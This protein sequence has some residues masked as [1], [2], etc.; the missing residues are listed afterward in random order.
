MMDAGSF[1]AISK[2]DPPVAARALH[3]ALGPDPFLEPFVGGRAFRLRPEPSGGQPLAEALDDMAGKH[4]RFAHIRVAS[5][6][7][8]AA[9]ALAAAGFSRIETLVTYSLALNQASITAA[10][11]Q[12]AQ[13]RQAH[14]GDLSCCRRI[15]EEAFIWNRFSRDPQMSTA[16]AR[17][18]KGE[19]MA[20]N[21]SGRAEMILVAETQ[22]EVGGFVA[23][24]RQG[25][26]AV[27]D[28]VAVAS[29]HR[30]LGLGRALLG[31]AAAAYSGRAA[32]LRAG[33]QAGNDASTR[34][35]L[36]CGFVPV[37]S[38]D[39]FHRWWPA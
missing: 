31:A 38:Q 25:D 16:A 15:A 33:T 26:D 36:S 4:A 14:A 13:L 30:G 20:S 28:L 23:C 19:W 9:A 34:L 18:L 1:P 8:P 17:A 29:E 24:L 5:D 21:F 32:N 12:R 22:D 10:R 37:A 6:D 39:T 27:I 35:Y 3:V 11:P 2:A 7:A